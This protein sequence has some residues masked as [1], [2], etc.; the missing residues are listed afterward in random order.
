M[1]DSQE[2]RNTRRM[3]MLKSKVLRFAFFGVVLV[4]L[5]AGAVSLKLDAHAAPAT[6]ATPHVSIIRH[7]AGVVF[8]KTSITVTHGTSFEFLNRTNAS[9]S[10]VSGKKTVVTIAAKSSS[11]YTFARKGTFTLTL[12]SNSTSTLTVTVQ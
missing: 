9:Q 11:P 12:Q 10:V 5:A 3:F 1:G 7:G 4:V 6:T 8:G 2:E